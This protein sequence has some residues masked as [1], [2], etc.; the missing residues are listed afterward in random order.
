MITDISQLDLN[1]LYSYADYLSWKFSE[2]VELI[3]GKIFR[4]SPAPTLLHQEVS[5]SLMIQIG[6]F[7]K[8]NP[9][10]VFHAPFDVRLA[11]KSQ[12]DEKVDTVVQPDITV[13]CDEIK[14]DSRG[15]HGAPDLVVEIISP[16]S[17]DKDLHEKYDQYEA[18]GVREYWVV[19][20]QEGSITQF[21]LN[22]DGNYQS[23]RPYSFID[24]IASV[25]IPGL[26]IPLKDIFPK[27]LQEPEGEY[28]VKYRS[29]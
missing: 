8:H 20:P 22:N 26:V 3:R 10:R 1:K 4:M 6:Q 7:L 9:C 21:V 15:C 2:R 13:V 16:S 28:D 14:L 24:D 27:T 5:S 12:A 29:L 23:T 11:L 18:A 25:A 19:F 17:A